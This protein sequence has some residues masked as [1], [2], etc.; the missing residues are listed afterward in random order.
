V[1]EEI[2]RALAAEF[3]NQTIKVL[4][5]GP[6]KK[7]H[8]VDNL[9]QLIG[10]TSGDWIAIFNGPETL[11]GQFANVKITRT[12]PLTLFGELVV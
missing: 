8:Q 9:P 2:S 3:T 6:S 11:A 12:S 1:Q 4:V 7:S 5:E 10:R